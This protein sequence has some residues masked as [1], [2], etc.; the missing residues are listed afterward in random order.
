[1]RA[2]GGAEGCPGRCPEHGATLDMVPGST[3]LTREEV[4]QTH[5]YPESAARLVRG[6]RLKSSVN[7]E[8]RGGPRGSESVR[9]SG[10]A[11]LTPQS[12]GV[13]QPR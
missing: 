10:R 3:L 6:Q 12:L 7:E 9:R 4:C 11:W 8:A 2:S 5:E 1:M 13:G